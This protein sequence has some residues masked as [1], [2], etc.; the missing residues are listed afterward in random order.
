MAMRRPAGLSSSCETAV[1][2]QLEDLRASA[3]TYLQWDGKLAADNQFYAEQNAQVVMTAE[4]YYRALFARDAT[5]WNLRDRHMAETLEALGR[6]LRA[7]G[8]SDRIVVWAHN[9]HLG[10]A[11]ATSMSQRG[12]LNL[13]QLTRVRLGEDAVL[14]G[15]TTFDGTVTAASA[16][17]GHVERKVVRPALAGSIEAL[18][19]QVGLPAFLLDFRGRSEL[20]GA[21]A[22]PMLER[23]IGVIYRPETERI[24]HYFR[25]VIP[26]QFDLLLHYDRTRALEPLERTP[27]WEGAAEELPDTYPTAL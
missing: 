22:L 10:D 11:R 16:W 21:L 12:E 5:A 18:C 1:I 14:V 2:R 17:D 15:F 13:G 26:H 24:S 7:Q 6:H 20:T 9:S 23:A 8:R 27:T 25:A 3:A 19:H 4:R